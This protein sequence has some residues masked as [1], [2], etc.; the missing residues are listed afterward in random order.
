M[1]IGLKGNLLVFGGYCGSSLCSVL[2][3]L[4]L[5]GNHHCL[6]LFVGELFQE[7][8]SSSCLWVLFKRMYRLL[9]YFDIFISVL[10]VFSS[11]TKGVTALLLYTLILLHMEVKSKS[12]N[13]FIFGVLIMVLN[14]HLTFDLSKS[15]LIHTVLYRSQS[16]KYY[17]LS[18]HRSDEKFVIFQSI[19]IFA[20]P[21]FLLS[22]TGSKCLF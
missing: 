7:S 18:S 11:M 13:F 10:S 8:A 16:L 12:T 1:T 6:L 9:L 4:Q 14:L 17:I 19:C 21:R 2:F 15:L 22:T 3:L 20:C 5:Q